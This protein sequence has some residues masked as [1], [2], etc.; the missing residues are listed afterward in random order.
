MIENIVFIYIK[1]EWWRIVQHDIY[2]YYIGFVKYKIN[3]VAQD[4]EEMC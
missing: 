1:N 3:S 4:S 2:I